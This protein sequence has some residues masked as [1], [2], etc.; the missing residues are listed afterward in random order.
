MR[1]YNSLA[2]VNKIGQNVGRQ[3]ASS[4][5]N[6]KISL[7]PIRQTFRLPSLQAIKCYV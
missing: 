2:V 7:K 5:F 3:I 4:N 6:L 1:R